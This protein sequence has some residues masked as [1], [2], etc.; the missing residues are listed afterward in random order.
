VELRSGDA[1][2]EQMLDGLGREELRDQIQAAIAE[3]QAVQDHR[4]RGRAH[5]HL[6]LARPRQRIQIVRQPDIAAD[7]RY[8]AQMI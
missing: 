5:T 6:L 8:N 3:A 2:A 4:H 1:G 7:A